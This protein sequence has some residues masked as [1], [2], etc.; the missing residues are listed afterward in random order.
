MIGA[1]AL[2]HLELA[3]S[4][5]PCIS[6]DAGTLQIAENPDHADFRVSFTD[7]PALA[8]VRV[9]LADSAETADFA[10][11]DDAAEAED[12]ACSV[13]R[14]T[15]FV[16]ISG[17]SRRGAAVIYLTRDGPADFRIFVDSR[18]FSVREAAALVVGAHRAEPHLAEVSL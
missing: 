15:R 6:L 12:G 10:V 11:V 18:R 3:S 8:S 1:A 17:D 7:D 14:A 13:S 5:H 2:A 9:A 4:P 16:A